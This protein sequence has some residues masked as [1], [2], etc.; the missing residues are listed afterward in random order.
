MTEGECVNRF[1]LCQLRC[2]VAVAD[3]L[4]FSRAA[5]RLN[6]TQPPLSR[7]IQQLEREL[8]VLL[9]ERSRRVVKLTA[10]GQMF[11]LEARRILRL[12]D[13]AV[14]SV[15]QVA[16][17]E[18][19]ISLGF[20]PASSYSLLPRL[21]SFLATEMSHVEIFLKEMATQDQIEA[22]SANRI[23]VGILRPPID[24]R[25][26]ESVYIDR[27]EFIL[28][29]QSGRVMPDSRELTLRDLDKQPFIMY[30][31]IES[32][33]HH[34]LVSNLL[35]SAGVAP[36]FIQ[37]AQEV[38]TML[39]LVG[40]GIGVALVPEGARKLMFNGVAFDP[41]KILPKTYSEL[42]LVWRQ[43]TDNPA[44]KVFTQF[45]LPKFLDQSIG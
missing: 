20:L 4:H 7:K 3:E 32:R 15:Q 29:T 24:N 25:G 35:R 21:V 45:L 6:M 23:D 37:Y 27:E 34:D 10:A 30:A 31:P 40:A 9:L 42:I 16:N 28:A 26:L 22:L 39:A 19:A 33:Y 41:V 17:S 8:D 44:L 18:G 1:E 14:R 36:Q 11:L 38:H 13:D 5:A 2:F 12:S 43:R